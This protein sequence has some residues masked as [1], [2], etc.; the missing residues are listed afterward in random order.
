METQVSAVL[1]LESPTSRH[2]VSRPGEIGPLGLVIPG[3]MG[4][5]R[6]PLKWGHSSGGGGGRARN[7]FFGKMSGLSRGSYG[8]TWLLRRLCPAFFSRKIV[9]RGSYGTDY[10]EGVSMA[11]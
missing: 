5:A 2:L 6:G 8:S 1:R 3:K 4:Y 9:L 7:T 10:R 11:L